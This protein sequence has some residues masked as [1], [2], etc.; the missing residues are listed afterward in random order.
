MKNCINF[1]PSYT[2]ETYALVLY[3]CDKFKITQ[4]HDIILFYQDD[5]FGKACL[6]GAEKALTKLGLGPVSQIEKIPYTRNKLDFVKAL[7][8][9]K[10]SPAKCLGLFAT[11]TA[12]QQLLQPIESTHITKKIFGISTIA[13]PTFQEFLQKNDIKIILSHVVPD[14]QKSDL[15][16]VREYRQ[17]IAKTGMVPMPNSLEAYINAALLLDATIKISGLITKEALIAIMERL[18]RCAL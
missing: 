9:I 4:P 5:S 12:A 3:L 17:L 10:N 7:E 18:C 6:E 15:P 2:E 13:S 11:P 8:I 14:P 1:R 16:I